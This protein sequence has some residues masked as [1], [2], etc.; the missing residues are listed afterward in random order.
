MRALGVGQTYQIYRMRLG[1]TPGNL[2]EGC[3]KRR[4]V[5]DRSSHR[6]PRRASM[7]GDLVRRTVQL[8]VATCLV[9]GLTATS[10]LAGNPH[11]V[12]RPQVVEDGN[13]LTVSGKVA[14]LGNET[15]IHV[16]ATADAACLNPG[17]KFPQAENKETFSDEGDFPVQNGKATFEL[18]LVAS[19]QPRC[20]PPMT[21]VWGPVTITV[22][23]DT[24][25]TF[26]ITI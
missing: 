10:A 5:M 22:S 17:E 14:G 26:S 16:V 23:G 15:Q 13:T 25:A 24:F 8:L 6:C 11:F 4:E 1:G 9:L 7:E 3:L 20:S 19:F 12:G 18:M 21:V 2:M